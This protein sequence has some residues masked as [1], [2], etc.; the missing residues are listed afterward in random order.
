MEHYRRQHK[1]IDKYRCDECDFTTHNN[2]NL[3]RN[4]ERVYMGL[5]YSCKLCDDAVFN[6][7]S[8]L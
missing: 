6:R 5:S 4:M 1:N 3:V 7:E 2:A 8:G